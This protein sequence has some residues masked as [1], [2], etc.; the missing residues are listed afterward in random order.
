M[1]N[2]LKEDFHF[3]PYNTISYLEAGSRPVRKPITMSL[4]DTDAVTSEA[5]KRVSPAAAKTKTVSSAAVKTVSPTK[6]QTVESETVVNGT[7]KTG[8]KR[9]HPEEKS[10]KEKKEK[11]VYVEETSSEDEDVIPVSD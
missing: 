4:P 1:E 3:T 7:V 11:I 8:T 2:Y 9:L 5:V 10:G 6:C